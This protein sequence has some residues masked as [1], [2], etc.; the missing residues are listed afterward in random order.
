[1][2]TL[3]LSMSQAIAAG[4]IPFLIG[5]VAKAVAAAAMLPLAWKIVNK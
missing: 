1:M 2:I 3:G 4:V 5:D